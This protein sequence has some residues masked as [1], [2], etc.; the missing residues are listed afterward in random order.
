MT[1]DAISGACWV[2]LDAIL[3]GEA[4]VPTPEDAIG[5]LSSRE[6]ALASMGRD[7][8][9][10]LPQAGTSQRTVY[11]SRA[12]QIQRARGRG[13]EVRG[14]TA[15]SRRRILEAARGVVARDAVRAV[16]RRGVDMVIEGTIRVS[17]SEKR[18]RMPARGWVG[19]PGNLMRPAVAAWVRG[20]A[21]LA[22]WIV[23]TSFFVRYWAGDPEPLADAQTV[24]A[25]MRVR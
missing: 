3:R 24:T 7:P 5:R 1:P 20:D 15:A 21:D 10:P 22:G 14:L 8:G 16:I 9:G 17:E 19:I 23:S 4:Q 13:Q 2:A 18:V 25:E 6:L 12:R 11:R